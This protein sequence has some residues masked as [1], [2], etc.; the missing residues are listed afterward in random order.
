[1]NPMWTSAIR[2]GEVEMVLEDMQQPLVNTL[3]ACTHVLHVNLS[4]H[5]L[6]YGLFIATMDLE[7]NL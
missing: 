6:I 2:E 1:M 3:R 5:V 4:V 7:K